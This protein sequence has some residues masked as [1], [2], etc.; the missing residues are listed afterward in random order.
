MLSDTEIAARTQTAPIDEIA[1]RLGVE[2]EDLIPY[3]DSIAK[4]RINALA[5]PRPRL[6]IR[7]K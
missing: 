4:V 3:G 2:K 7:F 1:A 6:E 5:R